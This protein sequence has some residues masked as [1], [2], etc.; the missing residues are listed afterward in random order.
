M[1]I[2][3]DNATILVH[4]RMKDSFF[5]LFNGRTIKDFYVMEGRP[6][7]EAAKESCKQFLKRKITPTVIADNMAGFLFSINL[8]QE[9]WI[10][11][12]EADDQGVLCSI[13]SG[14]LAVLAAKHQVP[15]LCYPAKVKEKL[16]GKEKDLCYFN[17]QRTAPSAVKAYVP[18]VEWVPGKYITK[19][20]E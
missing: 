5:D 2:D 1:S 6:S 11:Y 7:L 16:L 17:G 13:G 10:A 4:G 9:V 12:Q 18:L 20:Y 14:I 3:L 19:I 8:V 15:V